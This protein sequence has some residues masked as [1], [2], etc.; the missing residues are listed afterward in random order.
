[1][2]H[3]VVLKSVG[4]GSITIHDPA[5]GLRRLTLADASRHFTGV[6]LELDPTGGIE[7]EAAPPRVCIR[8]LLGHV[9]GM[10]RALAWVPPPVLRC[11][12]ERRAL[13][14]YSG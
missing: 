9:T 6:A 2:N 3:F 5:E 11:S 13:G 12:R 7:L 1:M 4:R 10:R 14:R 8:A